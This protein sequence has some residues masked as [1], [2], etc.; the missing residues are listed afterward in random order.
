MHFVEEKGVFILGREGIL[1]ENRVAHDGKRLRVRRRLSRSRPVQQHGHAGSVGRDEHPPVLGHRGAPHV[2]EAGG[3]APA[4]SRPGP[5]TATIRRRISSA[6][7]PT[8]PAPTQTSYAIRSD[9]FGAQRRRPAL[10]RSC[11]SGGGARVSESETRPRERQPRAFDRGA[12]QSVHALRA[13]ANRW[14]TCARWPFW[15]S[16]IASRRTRARADGIASIS[17][18]STIGPPAATRSTASTPTSVSSSDSSPGGG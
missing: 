10:F 14:T 18:G 8:R 15:K 6:S 2:S 9:L 11:W 3:Q 12:V 7:A 1:S 4:T 5:R 13:S 16:T 17:R